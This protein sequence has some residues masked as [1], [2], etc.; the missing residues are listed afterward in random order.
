MTKNAISP[1]TNPNTSAMGANG[2]VRLTEVQAKMLKLYAD[3]GALDTFELQKHLPIT[4][5][6]INRNI[7]RL[8]ELKLVALAGRVQ[9]T[10]VNQITEQ[11][12]DWLAGRTSEVPRERKTLPWQPYVPAKLEPVRP[13]ASDFLAIKSLKY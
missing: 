5:A 3:R 8:V 4:H 10:R 13:G 6:A 7:A 2:L 11:G 1:H 12:L 9:N